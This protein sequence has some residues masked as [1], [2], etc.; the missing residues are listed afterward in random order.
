VVVDACVAEHLGGD[1]VLRIE[2]PLLWIEADTRNVQALQP[3]SATR[4]RLALDV[5]EAV[6]SVGELLVN[7]LG[8]EP[9]DPRDHGRDLRR[10]ADLQRIGVDSDRLLTDRELDARAVVDRAAVCRQLNRRPV[11]V[12]RHPAERLGADALEPDGAKQGGAEDDRENGEEKTD[13]AV[14]QPAAQRPRRGAMST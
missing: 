4:V 1:R 8:S 12:R 14:R 9:Q 3:L 7:L 2:A 10:I 11:L 6:R 13:P 5:D